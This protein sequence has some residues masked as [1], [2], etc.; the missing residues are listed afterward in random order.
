[1]KSKKKEI[2]PIAQDLAEKLKKELDILLTEIIVNHTIIHAQNGNYYNTSQDDALKAAFAGLK[3]LVTERA[4]G[5]AQAIKDAESGVKIQDDLFKELNPVPDTQ[6]VWEA[7]KRM[8]T[9]NEHVDGPTLLGTV[10]REKREREAIE[11]L[12]A[13]A[14][15]DGHADGIRLDALGKLSV[16]APSNQAL[17]ITM[18]LGTLG[19][20]S[21]NAT[22]G[23][24]IAESGAEIASVLKEA[25]VPVAG[26]ADLRR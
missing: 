10:R 12:R 1:M 3:R 2:E 14:D 22:D 15:G 17:K 4:S 6:D 25:G 19:G 11:T 7:G 20:G 18:A 9:A 13:C 5:D 26:Q 23:V 24:I 8:A 16:R 21:I